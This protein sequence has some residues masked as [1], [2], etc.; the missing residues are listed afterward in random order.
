MDPNRPGMLPEHFQTP[1]GCFGK[2]YFPVK[3][4]ICVENSVCESWPYMAALAKVTEA[5]CA[6]F[7]PLSFMCSPQPDEDIAFCFK[8]FVFGTP[9]L[10]K[11]LFH[12][13]ASRN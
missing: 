2:K 7:D 1:L 11:T 5:K 12:F 9:F 3:I 8:M 10:D 13:A 4:L 6:Y